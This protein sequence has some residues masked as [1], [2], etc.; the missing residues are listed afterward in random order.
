MCEN[1][2]LIALWHYHSYSTSDIREEVIICVCLSSRMEVHICQVPN[3]VNG[4]G[5]PQ[6]KSVL[7]VNLSIT[8]TEQGIQFHTFSSQIL[9]IGY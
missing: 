3:T 8:I 5:D 7:L 9:R 1:Y 4:L 6:Q 2:S